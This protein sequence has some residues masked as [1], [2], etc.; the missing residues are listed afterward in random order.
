MLKEG[1]RGVRCQFVALL[2][3]QENFVILCFATAHLLSLTG[4][5]IPPEL[6]ESGFCAEVEK[7]SSIRSYLIHVLG[8]YTIYGSKAGGNN[9]YTVAFIF[10]M[11]CVS[12]LHLLVTHLK[13]DFFLLLASLLSLRV[14]NCHFRTR[15]STMS[16]SQSWSQSLSEISELGQE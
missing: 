16:E 14:T 6:Y 4:L 7:L 5:V 3:Q 12:W 15:Y 13:I 1:K 9:T 10:M 2:Q 11:Q 8:L